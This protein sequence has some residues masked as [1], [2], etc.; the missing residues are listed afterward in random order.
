M[1][2]TCIL[3]S[4]KYLKAHLVIVK[5]NI[6]HNHICSN[7][8]YNLSAKSYT[9]IRLRHPSDQC[10]DMTACTRFIHVYTS[11]KSIY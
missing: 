5:I 1:H 11:I 6:E 8:F 9:Y 2:I 3:F 4:G 7:V 10:N